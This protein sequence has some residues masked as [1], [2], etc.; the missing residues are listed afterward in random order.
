M[1]CFVRACK[2]N[3]DETCNRN[4]Q[5]LKVKPCALW[6]LFTGSTKSVEET[7]KE[8]DKEVCE[9]LLDKVR[10]LYSAQYEQLNG[11]D[12]HKIW[13]IEQLFTNTLFDQITDEEA[14]LVKEGLEIC[15]RLL[16]EATA[17]KVVYRI[18]KNQH[19]YFE[20]GG[21]SYFWTEEKAEAFIDNFKK[22]ND[23]WTS[24][25]DNP[26]EVDLSEADMSGQLNE[27][28]H[29]KRKERK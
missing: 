21:T 6:L 7:V 8:I 11:E 1:K 14:K 20:N 4:P 15:G 9:P 28:R 16:R 24:E 29:S 25:I 5:E 10:Y 26:E 12:W 22:C 13:E 17:W 2:D 18:M 3:K 19:G 23:G 27:D